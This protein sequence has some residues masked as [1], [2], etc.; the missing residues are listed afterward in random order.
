[1]SE[2]VYSKKQIE[3]LIKK[4]AINPETNTL[5]KDIINMF[6]D[7]PNYQVWALKTV[8]SHALTFDNLVHI[9]NWSEA[10]KNHIKSLTKKN[11]VSYSTKRDLLSLL[12]EIDG[13]NQINFIKGIVS[14]FNTEQRHML[15]TTIK[16]NE[17][18]GLSVHKNVVFKTWF[19]ILSKFDKLPENRKKKFISLCSAYR[20]VNE[21]KVGLEKST[22][23]SYQWY[24]E[25]MLAFM[26]NNTPNCKIIFNQGNIVILEVGDFESS[27]KLCGGGRT[28]WC[29]TREK[30]YF[31]R[32]VTNHK[33]RIHKQYFF[34]N[35]DKPETDEFA[36]IG[37]TV[38]EKTGIVN[39]HST[40]NQCLMGSGIKYHGKYMNIHN[41]L[42]LYGVKK[43]IFLGVTE[44]TKYKWDLESFLQLVSH[45]TSVVDV[46]YQ[47]NNRVIVR[48]NQNK[49]GLDVI[50]NH[51]IVQESNLSGKDCY[52]LL[53]FNLPY[54]DSKAMVIMGFCKDGYG[55]TSLKM[56]TDLF[57]CDMMKNKYLTSIGISTEEFVNREEINPCILLHKLIDEGDEK[58]AIDLIN[59]NGESF[60]VNFIFH[61]RAPIFSAINN[62]M[63][64]LFKVIVHHKNFNSSADDGF[65]ETLLSSLLYMYGSGE[66]DLSSDD[67]ENLAKMIADVLES[68][69]VDFN[70]QDINLDTAIN[71]AAVKP[72]T[73]WVVKALASKPNVDINV[74]NDFNRSALGNA[75][76]NS[77]IEAIKVLG[78]RSDLIVRKEDK[79]LAKKHN[80]CLE[81]LIAPNASSNDTILTVSSDKKKV[82]RVNEMFKEAFR[83]SLF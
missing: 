24:K 37:F 17:L 76:A 58:G 64:K 3:P 27:R 5:F 53:D 56:I 20:D 54:D 40:K 2:V 73:V 15:E 57:G 36:H 45:M 55:L 33:D 35:F 63:Y 16:F 38:E 82:V 65:G 49:T 41:V 67:N 1:M 34:F 48:L 71:I 10:N 31:D 23:D 26:Q 60:D 59:K 42:D 52:I 39:A 18:D 61:E 4:Y 75:I 19:K 74:I 21:M 51:A 6:A 14:H 43:G 30:S 66:L 29:I 46:V 28:G 62:K 47:K 8:F 44:P 72:K 13:L 25:D 69:S 32:Y 22:E 68:E 81:E 9:K 11:I 7:K 50:A 70:I 80:I 12:K 83:N 78:Q 77:N 79:I